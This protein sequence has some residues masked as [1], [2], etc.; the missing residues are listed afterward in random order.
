MLLV[1][2][3]HDTSAKTLLEYPNAV[4]KN[5]AQQLNGN[6]EL[7]LALDNIYNHPNVA[8]F[9]SHFLIQHLVISDPTPAYVGRVAATF[10]ANR[11]NPSQMKEVVQAILLD[12]E[13]RGNLKTATG[14]GKLREPVQLAT[15]LMRHFG[16]RS[17]DG[18]T[19]S[20]GYVAH[21]LAASGQNV[22]YSPT[23]FNY[24]PPDYVIPGPGING[25]EFGIMTTST[26]I[27]RMNS[28]RTIVFSGVAPGANTTVGT[29]LNLEEMRMLAASD[30][31][32]NQLLDALNAKMLYG[33]MTAQNK[34]TIFTAIQTVPRTDPM[35]RARMAIYLI[36]TSSKYQVQR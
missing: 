19:E 28:V 7:E 21:L 22:F 33:R 18:A 17:A 6:A 29:S 3:N 5:I 30:H 13:A 11:T 8:P 35:L 25:P 32:G 10:N 36:A 12:P 1:Q 16:V 23:V 14:Y 9:V 31:S 34:A 26:A 20:D 4:N 24:Y 15:N 27:A 2:D